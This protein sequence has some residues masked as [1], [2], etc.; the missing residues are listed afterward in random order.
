MY[1]VVG[2]IIIPDVFSQYSQTLEYFISVGYF[3]VVF[4]GKQVMVPG[5]TL[6]PCLCFETGIQ[7]ILTT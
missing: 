3:L 1:L 5:K 2:K 7:Y 6:D 4:S